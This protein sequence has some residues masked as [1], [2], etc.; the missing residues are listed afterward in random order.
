VCLGGVMGGPRGCFAEPYSDDQQRVVTVYWSLTR[1]SD[2]NA[3][4]VKIYPLAL[5]YTF[6]TS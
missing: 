3:P 6:K 5:I 1:S 2:V 4:V